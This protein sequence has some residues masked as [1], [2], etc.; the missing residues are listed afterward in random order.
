MVDAKAGGK[1]W[2][3]AKQG[4][5]FYYLVGVARS[6]DQYFETIIR[7]DSNG[8]LILIPQ[9]ESGFYPLSNY[10]DKTIARN[11]AIGRVREFMKL[12]GGREALQRYYEDQAADSSLETYITTDDAWALQ[13]EGVKIPNSKNVFIVG[14][15]GVPLERQLQ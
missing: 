9:G 12:L 15:E 8:C 10:V 5:R 11:L 14:A 7:L 3:Q 4:E 13:R 1:L 6:K 2:A